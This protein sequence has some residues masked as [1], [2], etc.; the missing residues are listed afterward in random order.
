MKAIRSARARLVEAG[1]TIGEWANR[2]NFKPAVV[3]KV[4]EGKRMAI[5]G[6][7]LQIAI[8]LGLRP[9]PASVARQLDPPISRTP[10]G[11]TVGVGAAV[12]ECDRRPVLQGARHAARLGEAVR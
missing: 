5:R 9:E 2:H 6:E 1:E 4:L 8:A 12:D 10:T 7:S 3:Y 11:H